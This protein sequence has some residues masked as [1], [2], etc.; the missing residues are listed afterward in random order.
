VSFPHICPHC[1]FRPQE[2]G[3]G[4]SSAAVLVQI[5]QQLDA[6]MENWTKTLLDNLD[7]PSAR[8]SINLL[9]DRERSREC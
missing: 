1:I 7:D 6:L 4:A 9:P 5:D 8:K 3:M 2:E